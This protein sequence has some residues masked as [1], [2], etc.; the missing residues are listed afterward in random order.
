VIFVEDVRQDAGRRLEREIRSRVPNANVLYVDSRLA[1]MM[2]EQVLLAV[3]QARV[4]IAAV[5]AVPTAGRLVGGAQGHAVGVTDSSR[6]LL[7]KILDHAAGRTVIVAMGNP[8][9]AQDFPS[10][11]TYLCTFSNATVS[12]ISAVKGLFGEIPIH[13]HL[14]VTIPNIAERGTGLERPMQVAEGGG[15]VHP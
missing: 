3:D 9:L 5:Y 1:S 4:V 11:E 14:P 6:A 12:D 7:Q 8:Y 13:G 15:H 10:V 2:A